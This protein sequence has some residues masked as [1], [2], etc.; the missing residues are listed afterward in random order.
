MIRKEGCQTCGKVKPLSGNGRWW[1]AS[2][3]VCPSIRPVQFCSL[4][5]MEAK[6]AELVLE[7]GNLWTFTR[8]FA[9]L[10]LKVPYRE[11]WILRDKHGTPFPE[12][13]LDVNRRDEWD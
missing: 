13:S 3:N 11:N 7:S 5:C 10:H 4:A 1:E 2:V 12:A 8:T 9:L 6:K